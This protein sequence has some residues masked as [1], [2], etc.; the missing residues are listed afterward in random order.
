MLYNFA[1]D[2]FFTQRNFVGDFLR[3]KCDFIGKTAVLRF[4]DP[5]GYLGATYDDHL[6]RIGKRVVDFLVVLIELLNFLLGVT[7]EALRAFIGLKS[8]ISLQ[9][10]PVDQTFQVNGVA[11]TNHSFSQKARLN[12]ISY[13]IKIWTDFSS[14]LSQFTRLTD[15][16]T[17][18]PSLDVVCIPCSAVKTF[19]RSPLRP[20]PRWGSLQH[21]QEL[22]LVGGTRSPSSKPNPRLCPSEFIPWFTT[23]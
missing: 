19:G 10:G 15:G 21:S 18:F 5:L 12:D 17:E 23:L 13:D 14:F 4:W 20:V 7:A 3:A 2:I 22:L 9:R 1:S 8:A 11:P 16:R 6:R